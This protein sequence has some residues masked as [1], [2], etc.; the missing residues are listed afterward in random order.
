MKRRELGFT[1]ALGLFGLK[2]GVTV[3]SAQTSDITQVSL[4]PAWKIDSFISD[5]N[6][7]DDDF[8]SGYRSLRRISTEGQTI[9]ETTEIPEPYG[10]NVGAGWRNGLYGDDTGVYVGARSNNEEQGGRIYALDAG[11]GEERWH[12]EEP[13]DGLHTNVRSPVRNGQNILYASMASGSGSDQRPTVRALDIETGSEQWQIDRPEEFITGLFIHNDRLV[14]QQTFNILFYDLSS[15][16]IIEQTELGGGFNRAVQRGET[17][18]IPGETMYAVDIPSASENWA[19]ETGRG[20]NTMAS[21]GEDRIYVG[22]EGGYVLAHNKE[23]G[24]QLWE[25]RIEGQIEYPPF[26]DNSVIWVASGT[27][28]IYALSGTSGEVVYQ[29]NIEPDLRFAISDGIL[30][31]NHRDTAF[32]IEYGSSADQTQGVVGDA[33]SRENE[34]TTATE[35]EISWVRDNGSVIAGGIASVAGGGYLV[36]RR[37]KASNQSTEAISEPADEESLSSSHVADEESKTATD[38]TTADSEVIPDEHRADAEA[39]I[40][41]AVTA[42]SNDNYNDAA[43][44]YSEALSEY[45]SALGTLAA[46]ATKKREEIET[47]IESTRAELE[48]VKTVHEQRSEIIDALRPAERILQ[49]A[50]AAYIEADQTIARIRFRQARDTFG[51]AHETIVESEEDLLSEPVEV[52]G[53]PDRELSSTILSDLP[54]IPER[55]ATALSDARIETVDDLDSRDE[56]P[57]M[58]ITVE[59][60][61]DDEMIEE[62]IATTLVLLSWWHG[63]KSYEFDTAEAVERRQQQANYGFNH[64]S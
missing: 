36:W 54:V 15:R 58:P 31:D 34:A 35:S 45:Q 10:F 2:E 49:E 56:S 3:S 13:A 1:L 53:Q 20:V 62:D 12:Y 51:D 37:R 18:Y 26:V 60:M 52:S 8:V 30:V 64:T 6:T 42:K 41:K 63:D 46:G 44:A 59:E 27:G 40:E 23:S 25:T 50:I 17:L 16:E 14:V 7:L 9:F 33:D 4:N 24:Q 47:A 19:T 5:I 43:E 38:E 57:W 11:T 22:T 32:E 61:V 39:A 55:A 48:A 28:R 29:K 21:V